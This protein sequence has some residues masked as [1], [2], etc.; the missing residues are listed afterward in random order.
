MCIKKGVLTTKA[1]V[2]H[3]AYCTTL[4]HRHRDLSTC[5]KLSSPFHV[6]KVM[7]MRK[8]PLVP[9]SLFLK[10]SLMSHVSY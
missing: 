4:F 3:S 5:L 1:I 6:L 7:G 2:F 10:I 8:K 9:S